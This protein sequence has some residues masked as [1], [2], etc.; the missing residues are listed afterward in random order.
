M[1]L[2]SSKTH[3][4]NLPGLS[5]QANE[6][7]LEDP[8]DL[9]FRPLPTMTESER[10]EFEAFSSSLLHPWPEVGSR[11]LQRMLVVGSEGFEAGWIDVQEG[12]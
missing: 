8:D 5:S 1:L 3:R 7:Q 11:S 4:T 12:N 2:E 6:P 9:D 10:G